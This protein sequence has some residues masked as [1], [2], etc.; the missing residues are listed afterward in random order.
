MCAHCKGVQEKGSRGEGRWV[1]ARVCVCVCVCV[2]ARA[3]VLTRVGQVI[4]LC[5]CASQTNRD[6]GDKMVGD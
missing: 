2:C 4:A 6:T 3:R 1:R 5:R